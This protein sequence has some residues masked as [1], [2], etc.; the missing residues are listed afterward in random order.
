M[1]N[2]RASLWKV[3]LIIPI[4]SLMLHYNNKVLNIGKLYI[5]RIEFELLDE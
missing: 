2:F 3:F 1:L 4:F 5:N